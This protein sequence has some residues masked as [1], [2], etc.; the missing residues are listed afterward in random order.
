MR[1]ITT[2]K[3]DKKTQYQRDLAETKLFC[4]QPLNSILTDSCDTMVEVVVR[5]RCCETGSFPQ[6]LLVDFGNEPLLIRE[7]NID[8]GPRGDTLSRL[9]KVRQELAKAKNFDESKII[10]DVNND[11]KSPLVSCYKL[12]KNPESF[13]S[14]QMMT[15]NRQMTPASYPNIMHQMLYSEEA[16]MRNLLAR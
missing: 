1:I 3:Q 12:P 8:V 2:D 4:L 9:A 6:N 15:A 5:F 14:E 11:G 16:H 13:V 7:F 10:R